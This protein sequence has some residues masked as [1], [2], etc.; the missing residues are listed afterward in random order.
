MDKKELNFLISQKEG[1]NL[2]F[3]ESFSDSISKDICAFANASGGKILIGVSDDGKV[4]GINDSNKLRSQIQDLVRNF[5][6][7]F[8]IELEAI[9]NILI[10]IIPEGTNK[11][12]SVNG[13]FYIR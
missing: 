9:D 2:E 3:K 12:Y 7:K 13:K 1:Y 6:P 10:I 5:D 11:P 4:K 8:N